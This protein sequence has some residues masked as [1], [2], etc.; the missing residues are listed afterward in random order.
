MAGSKQLPVIF[1]DVD[2]TLIPVGAGPLE[3]LE[4]PPRST[5]S[6]NPLLGRLNPRHGSRLMALRCELVW[7]TTWLADANEEIAPR[8]GLPP[9]PFVDW[10]DAP[11]DESIDRL[12]WKT[13]TLV[14]WAAGRPFIWVDDEITAFDRVWV[15]THHAAE[16]LLQRVSPL[17]GVTDADF[18]EM[19]D[20]LARL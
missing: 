6:G 15:A 18:D 1:L 12:H 8:L 4:V 2:G 20:W 16:A 9:L 3:R 11:A 13:R 7:A 10:A 17:R 19:S 5:G 14:A